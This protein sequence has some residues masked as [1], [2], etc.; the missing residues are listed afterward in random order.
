MY[1]QEPKQFHTRNRVYVFRVEK[2]IKVLAPV[3]NYRG[4]ELKGGSVPQNESN[5]PILLESDPFFL[6]FLHS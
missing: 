2:K 1:H 3:K 5:S 4:V 6:H